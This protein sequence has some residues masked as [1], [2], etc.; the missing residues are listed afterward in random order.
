MSL[1]GQDGVSDLL[2][3]LALVRST[4]EHAFPGDYTH[5]KIVCCDTVVVLA[6][7]LG[8][9]IPWCSTCLIRI[10]SI[11][12]PFSGD[13]EVSQLQI[14]VFVKD[15]VLRLD[16]PMDDI[17]SMHCF[18]CVYQT[19]TEEP[20]LLLAE[21]ALACQVVA[22]VTTEQEVHHE[23]EVLGIL[24]GVV[25]VDDEL[26][27]DHGEEL[28]FVHH[29]LDAFLVHHARLQH[30]FHCEL[31][32]FFSLEPRAADTP[33]FSETATAN[34]ILVVEQVFVEGYKKT[35]KNGLKSRIL[36]GHRISLILGSE[37]AITHLEFKLLCRNLSICISCQLALKSL[38]SI[39]FLISSFG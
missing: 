24:E 19:S 34:G 38:Y 17:V 6:H 37:I 25:R 28:E 32:D 33:H 3:A 27:A 11:W 4:A 16:I 12:Y 35:L 36:T 18:E 30:F 23:I 15:Q 13:T 7:Y 20:R 5:C 31:S 26:G 10:V 21:S 9:H 22:K 29:R 14:S 8:C 1:L 2:S 39:L